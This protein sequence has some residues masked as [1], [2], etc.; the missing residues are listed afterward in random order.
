[1]NPLSLLFIKPWRFNDPEFR[2]I[3]CGSSNGFGTARGLA[4]LMGI[5]ANGGEANGRVLLKPG[6]IERLSTPL[7]SGFDRVVLR[8]IT[9]GPG[10]Q[11]I[12][13]ADDNAKVSSAFGLLSS[14][15]G[16]SC[17]FCLIIIHI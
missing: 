1:M 12:N 15:I 2:E 11:I 6:A 3:E 13:V 4:R 16:V 17:G 8:N 5:V 7:S 10:T 9:Y 14:T